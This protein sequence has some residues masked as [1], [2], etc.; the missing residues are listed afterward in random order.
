MPIKSLPQQYPYKVLFPM[1]TSAVTNSYRKTTSSSKPVTI[2]TSNM[3][4]FF[5]PLRL[6]AVVSKV[7]LFLK[8]MP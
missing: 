3:W 5:F 2:K 4:S 8:S 6:T 1:V 7:H